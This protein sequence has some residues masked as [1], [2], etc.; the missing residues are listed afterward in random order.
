[1]PG[2]R[3][4]SSLNELYQWIGEADD[5]LLSM[6]MPSMFSRLSGD[7]DGARSDPVPAR[8]G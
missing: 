3:W 1:M 6:L 4:H 8:R 2:S 5:E 7:P